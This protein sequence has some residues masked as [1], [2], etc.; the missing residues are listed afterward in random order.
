ME[1]RDDL[2]ADRAPM[3][4]D[5][6]KGARE[7]IIAL[8]DSRAHDATVCPSEVARVLAGNDDQ[9]GTDWRLRMPVVHAAVDQL[10]TDGSVGLSWKG[11]MLSTRNGPYR[12]RR[13]AR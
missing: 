1:R 5:N 9:G 2:A 13:G 4:V 11:Q 6:S 12:I 8:L 10:L 3:S 7:A